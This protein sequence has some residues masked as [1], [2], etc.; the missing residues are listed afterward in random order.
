MRKTELKLEPEKTALA[1]V[2]CSFPMRILSA[3]RVAETRGK[4]EWK[5]IYDLFIPP[6]R[7]G[8]EGYALKVLAIYRAFL[9][10]YANPWPN[11]VKNTPLY[12]NSHPFKLHSFRP[13]L[14]SA[15]ERRRKGKREPER[16]TK[17]RI[18]EADAKGERASIYP[19]TWRFQSYFSTEA[20]PPLIYLNLNLTR[21]IMAKT[22]P[23]LENRR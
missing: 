5:I 9:I 17:G 20:P 15:G 21:N 14:G 10:V 16:E 13:P 1:F 8:R 3:H 12:L 18:E 19:P 7:L 11:S 23:P 2:E 6:A 4:V 22:A